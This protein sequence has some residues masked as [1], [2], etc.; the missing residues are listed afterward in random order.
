MKFTRRLPSRTIPDTFS[1]SVY[2]DIKALNTKNLRFTKMVN[3]KSGNSLPGNIPDGQ[4]L[5][6]T[7]HLPEQSRIRLHKSVRIKP[8]RRLEILRNILKLVAM[9][10]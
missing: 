9:I 8:D 5:L 3:R 4:P 6:P 7:N 1:H 10:R 2:T